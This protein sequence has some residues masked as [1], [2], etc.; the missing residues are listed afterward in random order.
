VSGDDSSLQTVARERERWERLIGIVLTGTR[1]DLDLS[2]QTVAE[3]LGW[4][5]NM[6]ANLESGRRSLRLTD[7]FLIA[8][9]LNIGPET[10]MLRIMRWGKPHA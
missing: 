6:V 7:L 2:Q 9:V 10:L 5:R 1:R 3:R 4:T 8:R